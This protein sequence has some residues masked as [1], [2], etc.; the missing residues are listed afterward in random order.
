MGQEMIFGEGNFA[1]IV[2]ITIPLLSRGINVYCGE[3]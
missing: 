2:D 1:D 3:I